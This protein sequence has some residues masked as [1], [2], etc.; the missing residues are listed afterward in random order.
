M[1]S[2]HLCDAHSYSDSSI[3]DSL[4]LYRGN[5]HLIN[6]HP[7]DPYH[8]IDPDAVDLD[9]DSDSYVAD[10]YPLDSHSRNLEWIYARAFKSRKSLISGRP[11]MLKMFQS[12]ELYPLKNAKNLKLVTL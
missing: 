1:P 11:S 8:D 9:Y 10:L 12:G 5:W 6:P 4:D 7:I 3:V 2:R